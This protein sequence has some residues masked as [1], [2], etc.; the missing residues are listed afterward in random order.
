MRTVAVGVLLLV[1]PPLAW[2]AGRP[3][4]AVGVAPGA[5]TASAAA[6]A[7]AHGGRIDATGAMVTAVAGRI[8]ADRW[9]VALAIPVLDVALPVEPVGLDA[10]GDVAIPSSPARVGWDRRAAVPGDPGTAVLA[11]H[12]DSRTEGLGAFAGLV[13]L[14]VGD[15]IAVT[16]AAG[17][18]A[19][20][21]VVAR[22][23]VA[24]EDLPVDRLAAL[25]G[26]PTLALVTCGGAFDAEARRYAENVIVW[27]VPTGDPRGS[28]RS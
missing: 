22:E 8:D 5:G 6:P 27:A 21:T 24:K 16:D 19:S 17:R 7:A 2:A 11:A 10:A 20:W 25:H 14:A 9:P 12:V 23:A 1:V 28:P 26:P 13:E 4:D 15:R 3:A 18:V